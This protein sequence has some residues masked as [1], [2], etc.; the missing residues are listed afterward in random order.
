MNKQILEKFIGSALVIN[1]E[2][3][4]SGSQLVSQITLF[5]NISKIKSKIKN[6]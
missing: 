4:Y 2:K 6:H 1:F 3:N 5:W